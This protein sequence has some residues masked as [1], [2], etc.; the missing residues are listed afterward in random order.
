MRKFSTAR[1]RFFGA[2]LGTLVLGICLST[3]AAQELT[4]VRYGV[5]PFQD[6]LLPIIGEKMGWYEEEGLDVEFSILGWAEV[7]EALAAGVVDVAVNN[8]SSVIATH[9]R[10]PEFVYYYGFNIFTEGAALMVRP[11]TFK[12]IDQIMEEQGLGREEA[13]HEAIRQLEGKTVVTTGNTDMEQAVL[14]AAVRA[15]LDWRRDLRIID[16]DPDEGLAAFL[17][18]TGDAYLGG[19]PQRIRATQEGM[20]PLATGPDLA[21][22]PINGIV[23][24]ETFLE[25]N[26]EALLGLV[27]VWFRIVDYMNANPDE[28]AKLIIDELNQRTGARMTV[29]DFQSFWNKLEHFPESPAAIEEIILDPNGWSYWRDRWDD[30]NWYFHEIKGVIDEPLAPEDAFYMDKAHEQYVRTY[31]E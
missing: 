14:G 24:T 11:D 13:I 26:P 8:I 10:F 20:V 6:T 25:N 30:S 16:M 28:G 7:Q 19:I 2:L 29:E 22:P 15:G 12:S 27:R 9:Q 1:R 18:G 31:G 5:S 4:K 3:G 23:T 17:T 21:P